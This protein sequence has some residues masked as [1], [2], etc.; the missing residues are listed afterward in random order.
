VSNNY[1][2]TTKLRGCASGAQ[3]TVQLTH[4]K[5]N[6][7]TVTVNTKEIAQSKGMIVCVSLWV[8]FLLVSLLSH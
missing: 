1:L 4:L 2:P 7:N 3:E 8:Y 6:R 5:I